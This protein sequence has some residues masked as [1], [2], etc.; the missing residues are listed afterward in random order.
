MVPV[1]VISLDL[2]AQGGTGCYIGVADTGCARN[3]NFDVGERAYVRDCE[4]VS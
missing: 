1:A 4:K 3:G 2:E